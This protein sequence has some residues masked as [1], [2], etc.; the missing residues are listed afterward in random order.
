MQKFSACNFFWASFVLFSTD[1]KSASNFA[2]CIVYILQSLKPNVEET[3]VKK[4]NIFNICVLE[5]HF[6]Y[7]SG[8][9]GSILFLKSQNHCTLMKVILNTQ[10]KKN[11]II[12]FHAV[13]VKEP[14][15]SGL[16]QKY[17]HQNSGIFCH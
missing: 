15:L 4:K 17:Y 8:Q 3:A 16:I 1:S 11:I 10:F 12:C 13:F 9:R 7:I 14:I 5:S 2:F 6:T